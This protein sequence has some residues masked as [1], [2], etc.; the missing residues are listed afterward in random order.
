MEE[1]YYVTIN[2]NYLKRFPLTANQSKEIFPQP[3][4]ATTPL[5]NLYDE[6]ILLF[7]EPAKPI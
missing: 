4:Q 5:D 3:N 1:T 7:D 2:D 6:F